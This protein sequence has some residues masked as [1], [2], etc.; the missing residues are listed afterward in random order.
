MYMSQEVYLEYQYWTNKKIE[1][2]RNRKHRYNPFLADITSL[3]K[4]LSFFLGL[5]F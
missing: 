3:G 4:N 2:D 5:S 1:K